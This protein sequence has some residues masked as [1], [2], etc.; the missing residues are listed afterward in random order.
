MF[1]RRKRS[2]NDF[3]A[4]V[5]SHIELETDRLRMQG[6]PEQE[7]RARAHQAFGNVLRS[8]ENFYESNHVIW[9]DHLRQDI[10]Y[11]LRQFAHSKA[12]TALAVITLALGI[13][14]NTAI[15]TLMYAVMFNTL[16]VHK[17][18]E[19]YRLG[20]GNN[21]CI[22][23]DYQ[24]GQDFGL[25]SYDLYR[26][27]RNGTPEIQNLAAFAA[28]TESSTVQRAGTSND[29]QTFTTEYVS[30]NY[31]DL[32][33]LTPAAGSFFRES[34]SQP[35]NAGVAVISYRAW[36]THFAH[37]SSI[38]GST[39]LI[40]GKPFT[41]VGVAPRGFYG[42]TL[43]T[44]PADLWMAASAEPL[45]QGS[46]NVFEN[47]DKEWLYLMGRL[48]PGANR[49]QV[50]AKINTEAR[51]WFYARA[52]S[53]LNAQTKRQIDAQFIPITSASGGV[54]LMS[55][56]YHDALLI[57][58]SL[59]SLVLLVACANVANLLL[60]RG[61]TL[62][63]QISLR[64]ALGASRGR[65]TRQAF[66]ESVLLSA[67]GGV[68][69]LALAFT[70]TRLILSL[71]FHGARYVPITAVPSLPVLG[72]A[73]ALSIIT[74][75]L[76]GMWPAWMQ[77]RSD[78]AGALRASARSTGDSASLPQKILVA[79]QA[80]L[81]L[82][83]LVGTGLLS[84]SLF[85]LEH[86][87]FGF[88]TEN[89]WL[90]HVDPAVT[91]YTEQ[92]LAA[93]YHRLQTELSEIPGVID[94]SL[95]MYAPMTYTNWND[96]I[97]V[98]GTGPAHQQFAASFV[99]VSPRYFETLGT[100]LLYG[101]TI[102]DRDR[103]SSPR[104]AVVSRT[105]ASIYFHNQNPLG[106]RF[107]VGS[108]QNASDYE[109]VGVVEDAKYNMPR[110]RAVPTFF[111]PLF[112]MEKNS[113]GSLARQDFINDIVLHV[114][115]GTKNIEGPVRKIVQR[116][117]PNISVLGIRSYNDQLSLMFNQERLIAT[118]TQLFGFLALA[119]ATI[120]LYGMVMLSVAR[121]TAEIGVRIALGATAENVI[122]MVLGTAV[123]QV[124]V[125][126]AFGVPLAL[127]GS[128]LLQ[129]QLFGISG[130]DPATLIIAIGVLGTCAVIGASLPA[131]RAAR[132]DPM[133]ALRVT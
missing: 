90:V 1:W 22:I 15:F 117:D 89:R 48:R 36:D 37:D 44:D 92:Q 26:T 133:N 55:I 20:R 86:Q 31:F 93:T 4:E 14:V 130:H 98:Q 49:M 32:F 52:S 66:T 35:A 129:H 60:A 126:V 11:S 42:E 29:S 107:G 113:D 74:G 3:S 17:P 18:T 76:F 88:Q 28:F 80:G 40:K 112:Q 33:E 124:C 51:N 53:Q 116:I 69:G 45:V 10:A 118:L 110:E 30:T 104:V 64:L 102:T 58:M 77:T 96:F 71:A 41:I 21:C 120:G 8:E 70:T 78:P 24:D 43:R 38:I 68:V 83:L 6:L 128:R 87:S 59:S 2:E 82:I 13:G 73:L 9:L 132:V 111:V 99:F 114:T 12:F 56:T 19:L 109:I 5:Q 25:F 106:K 95:S 16:P 94:V 125:G 131:R 123:V 50:E 103:P 57:L 121:R 105:F 85:K 67:F 62:R 27:L 46:N 54:D 97:W 47:P 84:Q 7:A 75:L 34:N 65:I 63:S 72:F 115:D 122:R 108:P 101:R 81:S 127:V 79:S 61:T 23:S 100:K 119:L 91:H 39:F